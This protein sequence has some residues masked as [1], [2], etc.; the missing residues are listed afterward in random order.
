MIKKL[1]KLFEAVKSARGNI[2]NIPIGKII[3][4]PYQPRRK[5]QEVSLEELA[6]SIKEQGLIQPI[7]VYIIQ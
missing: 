2:K 5:F 4:N 7:V 6:Q 1:R 3:P